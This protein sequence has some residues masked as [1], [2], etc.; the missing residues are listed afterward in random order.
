[1][2]SSNNPIYDVAIV[3]PN[4]LH[5]PTGG[6][7]E[8]SFLCK[9]L[10]KDGFK[11]AIVYLINPL[12]GLGKYINDYRLSAY[13]LKR[14][15]LHKFYYTVMGSSFGYYIVSPIVRSI[16]GIDFKEQYNGAKV[17]FLKYLD[18]LTAN[19]MIAQS[20]E[21]AFFVDACS[22]AHRK[23]YR[24]H[25]DLDDPSFSGPLHELAALSFKLPL[26]KIVMNEHLYQRFKDNYP[27]RNDI[28]I[29]LDNFPC[30][31]SP[32]ER[33]KVV[34]IPL[35]RNTSKGAEYA[36]EATCLIHEAEPE[37]RI[38]AFGNYP[39][40]KVP[41]FVEFNG[42]VSEKKLV[43]LYNLASVTVIPSIVEG[44]SFPALEAMSCGSSLV[45]TDNHG[46]T[47]MVTDGLDAIV[48]PVRDPPAIANAVVS[49][50][51]NMEKRVSIA[52]AGM[53]TSK[54]YSY[55]KTYYDLA[56]AIGLNR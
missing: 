14:P 7:M 10:V 22:T 36:I 41:D 5:M 42:T 1:M 20:W 40:E 27:I 29:E 11:V 39:K 47:S 28:G 44:T 9:R 48:V 24:V 6:D 46:V 55:E 33:K 19:V 56:K 50:L 54:K 53:N 12:K 18:G 16:L 49:L 15:I 30:L 4:F 52:K 25:H 8:V 2:P 34:L 51:K 21:A 37:A 17:L 3:I 31:V 43:E 13:L 38:I 32:L 35:R 23:F 26:K 45:T